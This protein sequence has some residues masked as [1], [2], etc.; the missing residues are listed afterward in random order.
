MFSIAARF[1]TRLNTGDVHIFNAGNNEMTNAETMP[2][3]VT[4]FYNIEET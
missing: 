1:K 2:V 3:N 4:Y